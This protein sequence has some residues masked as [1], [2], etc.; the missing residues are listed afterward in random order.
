MS[1]AGGGGHGVCSFSLCLLRQRFSLA[2]PQSQHV[3]RVCVC[4]FCFAS[5]CF[6]LFCFAVGITLYSCCFDLPASFRL[7][8]CV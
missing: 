6:V 5:F 2:Q 7:A 8:K 1:A 3:S 4:V